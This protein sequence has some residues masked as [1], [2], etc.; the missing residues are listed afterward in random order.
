M[1]NF[2]NNL[3]YEGIESQDKIHQV[4]W[5]DKTKENGVWDEHLKKK[6]KKESSS[7]KHPF[8][9]TQD[10]DDICLN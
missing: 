2:E 10:F 9:T 5:G 3:K 8:F 6:K 1:R 4:G 7:T